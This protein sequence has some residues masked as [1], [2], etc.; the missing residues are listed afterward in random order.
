M[1]SYC[2]AAHCSLSG[3]NSWAHKTNTTESKTVH[4]FTVSKIQY[5]KRRRI[6]QHTSNGKKDRRCFS[7]S[8]FR[9]VNTFLC[10]NKACLYYLYY[11]T[12]N[13][14]AI[15][16]FFLLACLF[17]ILS[18]TF[19]STTFLHRW[20]NQR[21]RQRRNDRIFLFGDFTSRVRQ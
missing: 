10:D 8:K 17:F 5:K 12:Y 21:C 7:R 6:G 2:G 14:A 18:S 16:A 4:E 1:D 19:R 15:A 11:N 20:E 13:I 9:F 3:E